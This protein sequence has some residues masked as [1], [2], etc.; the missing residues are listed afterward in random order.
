MAFVMTVTCNH[1]VLVTPIA[2]TERHGSVTANTSMPHQQAP[3]LSAA[4]FRPR[5]SSVGRKL[6]AIPQVCTVQRSACR[7]GSPV[8]V[9]FIQMPSGQ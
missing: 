6:T 3:S 4:G 9:A 7:S 2:H 1:V 8:S 5:G